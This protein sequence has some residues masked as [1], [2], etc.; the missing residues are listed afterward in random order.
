MIDA[1]VPDD[2]SPQVA[3]YGKAFQLEVCGKGIKQLRTP[4]EAEAWKRAIVSDP[5][6]FVTIAEWEPK[7]LYRFVK[8]DDDEE[9]VD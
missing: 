8:F 9:E 6:V 3:D 4:E 5:E 1:T 2:V 7:E